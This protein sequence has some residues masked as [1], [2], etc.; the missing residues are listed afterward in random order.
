MNVARI[1]P[2][3]VL[4]ILKQSQSENYG[5]RPDEY[6]VDDLL[7]SVFSEAA[8]DNVSASVRVTGGP[9]FACE[10]ME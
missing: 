3:V 7:G 8:A 5:A 6:L 10:V 2:E 9:P 4:A 1:E